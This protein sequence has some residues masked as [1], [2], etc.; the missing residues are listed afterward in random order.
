MKIKSFGKINLNLRVLDELVNG[1]HKI[2]SLIVPIDL[3][4]VI[5]IKEI[6]NDK[7]IISF[8]SM[9]I[10]ENN[11]VSKS[12]NLLR[13]INDFSKYFEINITKNI[14]T[15]SGLGGG[16]SNGGAILSKLSEVYNLSIPPNEDVAQKIGSDVPF[17]ISGQPAFVTGIGDIIEPKKIDIELNMLLVVPNEIVSTAKAFLEFDRLKNTSTLVNTYKDIELFMIFDIYY[18][19]NGEYPNHPHTLPW[20]GKKKSDICRSHILGDFK[21]KVDIVNSSL[22]SLRDGVYSYSWTKDMKNIDSKDSIRI[23]FKKY[24]EG[25]KT[26]KK[27]KKDPTIYTNEKGI[28][29][30]SKKILDLD[31]KDGYEYFMC[32]NSRTKMQGKCKLANRKF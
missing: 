20:I 6:K 13:E 32:W 15:E 23:G 28:C 12:L 31:K 24:Y 5:E 18:S 2:E 30:V 9:N 26:L 3:Y 7:D 21:Q 16:S 14:P 10:P 8:D 25:P 1:L 29:K 4:D 17:F 22:S 27:D 19:E 11:T